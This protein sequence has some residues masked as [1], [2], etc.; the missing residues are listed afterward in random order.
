MDRSIVGR[1]L[2]SCKYD[3]FEG[4]I[5]SSVVASVDLLGS[6]DIELP[7]DA[8]TVGRKNWVS[9]KKK[10]MAKASTPVNIAPTCPLACKRVYYPKVPTPTNISDN[11]AGHHTT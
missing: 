1:G 2:S 3:F 8:L 11:K 9:G 7:S 5:G 4:E 6:F 10:R